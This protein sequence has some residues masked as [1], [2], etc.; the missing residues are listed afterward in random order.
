[1]MDANNN[2]QNG[3]FIKRLAAE[4]LEMREAVHTAVRK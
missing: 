3:K 1:M 2:V 4:G